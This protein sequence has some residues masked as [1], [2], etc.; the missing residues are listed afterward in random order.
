MLHIWLYYTLVF[1]HVFQYI[2]NEILRLGS[3][4]MIKVN[5]KY[6]IPIRFLF[7]FFSILDKLTNIA[8]FINE[9]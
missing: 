9:K 3:H 8:T 2:K 7:S 6:V 1:R 5:C 4:F